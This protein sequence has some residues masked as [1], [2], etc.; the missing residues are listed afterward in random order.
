MVGALFG[1]WPSRRGGQSGLFDNI[2][3]IFGACSP[4]FDICVVE[5]SLSTREFPKL[6]A[7]FWYSMC[8]CRGS[9]FLFREPS[10]RMPKLH[11]CHWRNGFRTIDAQ[12]IYQTLSAKRSA[13]G[14][15]VAK[16]VVASNRVACQHMI[17]NW[18]CVCLF[19]CCCP[20][21]LE[22]RPP[23]FVE[24]VEMVGSLPLRRHLAH[25]E[26]PYEWRN[27]CLPQFRQLV[28]TSLRVFWARCPILSPPLF[29][30]G[31]LW[32]PSVQTFRAHGVVKRRHRLAHGLSG[33]RLPLE[34]SIFHM[35]CISNPSGVR[36]RS[37]IGRASRFATQ[38]RLFNIPLVCR[39]PLSK[40]TPKLPNTPKRLPEPYFATG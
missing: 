13:I 38:G 31:R 27:P 8:L 16:P 25:S 23:L 19:G 10:D 12:G 30:S 36:H 34:L 29:R 15:R 33:S 39:R 28:R 6:S 40:D 18:V 26:T 9:I 1:R 35:T 20:R 7:R 4:Y 24:A 17:R 2:F 14:N 3:A 21:S 5:F 32:P 22:V 11:V 37:A